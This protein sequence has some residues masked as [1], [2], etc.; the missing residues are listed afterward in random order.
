M[1]RKGSVFGGGVEALR[2]GFADMLRL[3]GEHKLEVLDEKGGKRIV[4][5][6]YS[7]LLEQVLSGSW[8]TIRCPMRSS[9]RTG[10]TGG[11]S[12][13]GKRISIQRTRASQPALSGSLLAVPCKKEPSLASTC[14]PNA[15]AS[16]QILERPAKA[17]TEGHLRLDTT[18]L[19]GMK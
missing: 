9:S 14:L 11:S 6:K 16:P 3:L 12:G 4:L 18:G 5:W 2:A 13:V 7:S 1:A 8:C 15:K 19:T 17:G 10:W